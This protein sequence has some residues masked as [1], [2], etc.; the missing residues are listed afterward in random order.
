MHRGN[1]ELG[2]NLTNG[3]MC[4]RVRR[5]SARE[6]VFEAIS[7]VAEGMERPGF[8]GCIFQHRVFRA[9]DFDGK[10]SRSG[11]LQ[12]DFGSCQIEDG[13]C[14]LVPRT[15]SFGGGMVEALFACPG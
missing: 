13:A 15:T 7:L 1:P 3:G 12:A 2:F 9:G 10:V 14:E 6:V 4:P 11:S 5:L 8:Q